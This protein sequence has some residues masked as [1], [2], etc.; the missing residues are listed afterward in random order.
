MPVTLKH[1]CTAGVVTLV[2]GGAHE[3]RLGDPR[4]R[5]MRLS[6]SLR[7]GVD[8]FAFAAWPMK[9]ALPLDQKV[10]I[11]RMWP[12]L[13]RLMGGLISREEVLQLA[14]VTVAE[15]EGEAMEA[16]V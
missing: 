15:V 1:R 14:F 6:R 10:M 3:P 11:S 5:S 12:A 13:K 16:L 7:I 9:F 8:R 2:S 4:N